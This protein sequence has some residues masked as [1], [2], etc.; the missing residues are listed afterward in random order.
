MG[1]PFVQL[2]SVRFNGKQNKVACTTSA[3]RKGSSLRI[4]KSVL[5]NR[6]SSVSG[7]GAT[8]PARILLERLFAQ[9]QKLEEQMSRNSRHP[10][11]VQL[12]F[13]LETLECDLH[14][15]LAALKK[16]EEDLQDA[17]RLVFL[18]HLELN[19]TKEELEQREEKTAAACS[20]YKKIEEELKQA[21]VDLASQ[22][23][24]I[25]H[26]KLQLRERPGGCCYTISTFFETR[27]IG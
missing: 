3:K 27:G 23:S 22:A 15:A 18:E 14:A 17:E 19:R 12:G 10:Q 21:N 5:N 7:N 9:T 25:E 16:K 4:S 8:E 6:K 13:N 26:L 11:D 24:H 2:C 1:A 20:R